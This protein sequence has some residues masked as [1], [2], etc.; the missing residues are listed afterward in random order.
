MIGHIERTAM[1]LAMQV[2]SRSDEMD[3]EGDKGGDLFQ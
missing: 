3:D 2:H 1:V